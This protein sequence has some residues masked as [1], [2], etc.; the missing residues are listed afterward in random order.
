[1]MILISGNVRFS[2]LRM[3]HVIIIL[4]TA[5]IAIF[6]DEEIAIAQS[7]NMSMNPIIMHV[8]PQSFCQW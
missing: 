5:I 8:H 7:D 6:S 3:C 4:V 2:V 1:M